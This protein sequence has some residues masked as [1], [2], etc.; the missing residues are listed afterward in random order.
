MATKPEA[1]LAL[2]MIDMR[3][4]P[5]VEGMSHF[6]NE[7]EFGGDE[8]EVLITD[9]EYFRKFF[10]ADRLAST[11]N[12][13]TIFPLVSSKPAESAHDRCV[14]QV[15]LNPVS[16]AFLAQHRVNGRPVLPFVV[17][18]E[19]MAETA[20]L[21]AGVSVN[22][23]VSATARQAL[24]FATDDALA[25]V[26]EATW[27]QSGNVLV[28]LLADVRRRDGR[29]V[30]ERREY[31]LG[32][33]STSTHLSPEESQS[34]R[35]RGMS[36]SADAQR[37][38]KVRYAEP[39]AAVW[40]GPVF[41]E[42]RKFRVEPHEVVGRIAASAPVQLFGGERS[43]GFLVP[44][45][46]FDACLYLIGLA[47][48]QLFGKLSLPVEFHDLWMGRLPDPGE[49]CEVRA[50]QHQ[51]DDRGATWSFELTGQNG[52]SILKVRSYRTGW[53]SE[54]GSP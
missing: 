7:L 46:T 8:S 27:Q 20:S 10:P 5:A 35:F 18:L 33:F 51:A 31:F 40:H 47:N 43:V 13:A 17:A 29:L 30:E 25:V 14:A 52:D 37:W 32:V 19:M 3:F 54:F 53:L 34:H 22:R 6:L 15:T 49:P 11:E 39:D 12:R 21:L 36:E 45:S 38:S 4:M 1:K 42:L 50:W 48:V 41:Q 44:C 16:D 28:R 24:R 23:C 26:L 9:E 2:E